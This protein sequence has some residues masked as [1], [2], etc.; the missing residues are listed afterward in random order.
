[1]HYIDKQ[2]ELKKIWLFKD[3]NI[4]KYVLSKYIEETNNNLFSK[5]VSWPFPRKFSKKLVN[6]KIYKTKIQK[7]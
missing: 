5:L 6:K 4:T 1:M 3:K 7:V 2:N